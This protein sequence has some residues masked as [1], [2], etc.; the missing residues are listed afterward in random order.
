[1]FQAPSNSF[2]ISVLL[3]VYRDNYLEILEGGDKYRITWPP[4]YMITMGEFNFFGSNK[5]IHDYENH[6]LVGDHNNLASIGYVHPYYRYPDIT[7]DPYLMYSTSEKIFALDSL[8]NQLYVIAENFNQFCSIGMKNFPL[9]YSVELDFEEEFKWFGRTACHDKDFLMIQKNIIALKDFVMKK[10][11]EKI[12][13]DCF[14]DYDFSFCS[15]IDLLCIQGRGTIEKLH[16][17]GY[18]VIGTAAKQQSE[19]NCRSLI[20][21]GKNTHVYVFHENRVKK[22]ATTLRYFIRRGFKEL[23]YREKFDLTW[24]DDKFF[25]LSD[26]EVENLDRVLNGEQPIIRPKPRHSYPRR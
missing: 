3:S 19:P 1:M 22:V 21:I 15:A 13:I 18:T 16:N 12:K 23:E 5:S 20:L 4:G 10:C 6:R 26:T 17:A 8:S 24:D 7:M 11:G 14:S 2:D 9:Y 25:Y